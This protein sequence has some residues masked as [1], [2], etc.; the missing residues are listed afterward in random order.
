MRK[1]IASFAVVALPYI[2]SAQSGSA[3]V[4]HDK[5][6]AALARGGKLID[7]G[8]IRVVGGHHDKPGPLPAET[9][10]TVFYITDGGGQLSVA[11]KNYALTKSDVIVVPA[12]ASRALTTVS[13]SISYYQVVVPVH[14]KDA[15]AEVV[16]VGHEKVAPTLKKAGPIADGPNMRV[17]GGYRTGPYAPEDYRPDV[18]IHAKEADLF[19]VIDGSATQVLGGTVVGGRDTAPGQ[20][21]GSKI[22]G[23]QTYHLAKGDVMWVPAGVPHWFPEIPQPLSYLLVKVFY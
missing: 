23:G 13:T 6:S 11:G 14:A 22:D 10:T 12:G 2:A 1:V 4:G 5:V 17:S 21:R 18:E 19:Y 20:I 7:D 9:G 8:K 15:K 16:H 3:Y